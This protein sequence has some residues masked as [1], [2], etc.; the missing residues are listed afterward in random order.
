[1]TSLRVAVGKI[2]MQMFLAAVSLWFLPPRDRP[3]YREE[4][5]AAL[6]EVA[7]AGLPVLRATFRI[8]LGAP[9]VGFALR[10]EHRRQRIAERL[11]MK[12]R[13]DAYMSYSAA[14]HDPTVVELQHALIRAARGTRK[15]GITLFEDPD[16]PDRVDLAEEAMELSKWFILIASPAA[17]RSERVNS[18]VERWGE[19]HGFDRLLIV[20]TGGYIRWDKGKNSFNWNHTTALPPTLE[21]RSFKRPLCLD[22]R[23]HIEFTLLPTFPPAIEEAELRAQRIDYVATRLA[24]I[25]LDTSSHEIYLSTTHSS[26][27]SA[28]RIFAT[29]M[30][31]ASIPLVGL[32]FY[33]IN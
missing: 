15:Q 32:T 31:L 11:A 4:W 25:C 5:G 20:Q 22:L 9:A 13:I 1:M 29:T 28:A 23:P 6:D 33:Q 7:E 21:G 14:F 17:A 16:R 8:L 26:R 18:E 3:R 10:G 27:L 2:R 24:A 19:K 30:L 12:S